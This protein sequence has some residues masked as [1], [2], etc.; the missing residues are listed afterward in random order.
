MKIKYLLYSVLTTAVLSGCIDVLDKKDLSAI[1]EKDVW[2]NAQYATAYLNK[3]YRDN[4][5]GWDQDVAGYSDEAYGETGILYGHLTTTSIDNWPYKE[6]RNI[7]IMLSSIETGNIDNAT[8][9][10]LKAQAL[11]LRA[12]R[13]FQMV[14]LYG[15]VPMILEPQAL[16]DD[17]YV[18]RNKTSECIN[19]IIK[20]LDDAIDALPWKWTGDDEGRFTKATVMA[21]K[22]RILLYYASPQFNPENKAERWETAYTYNKMA[23]EQIEANGYGLYDSYE[24][25]LFDEINKEVLFVTRY[26]EPDVT[27]HWDAATRP[28]SEAQNYSGCNQ[29]T[30]EMVESYPMIT[31]TPITESPDYDPLHFWQ[32]RD[33]RFTSTI[34]YNGCKWELS[35]KKDRIQWTYQGHSTLNPSS[36]GFYCRKAINVSYTPYYTE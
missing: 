21:L 3:L 5:P 19:L 36:S 24:N 33:P 32:N 27:H 7:N 29:P 12:W 14:R 25:V 8:K 2:N 15:G 23:A 31:G 20:D 4:L 30:K 16:T 28:L 26:Q 1:T 13:Y 10:S 6:I 17:L 35:G 18:T 22:G 9:T 11:V 34:A